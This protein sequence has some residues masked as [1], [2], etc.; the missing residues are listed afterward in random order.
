MYVFGVVFKKSSPQTKSL[1]F[2]PM[3]SFWGSIVLHLT[4][5]PVIHFELIFVKGVRFMPRFILLYACP[6][7]PAPFVEKTIF[8]PLCG[9]CSFVKY[10]L[11]MF[12]WV[13]F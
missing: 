4:F 3:L 1:S 2:S 9:L 5:R 13:Y 12:M 8:A 6:G 11:A 7:V 10:Q